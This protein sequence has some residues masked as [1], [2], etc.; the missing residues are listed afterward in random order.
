[1]IPKLNPSISLAD[2]TQIILPGKSLERFEEAFAQAAGSKYAISFPYGR[3]AMICLFE[4]LGLSDAEIIC[5]SYTCVVVPHAIRYSGNKPVFVDCEQGSYLMDLDL[6]AEAVTS[7]TRAIIVTSFFGEPVSAAAVARFRQRHPEV[8]VLQDCAH[9]F[10]CGGDHVPIHQN[11]KASIFGLNI[12]K[13][14]TSVFGGMVTTDDGDLNALIRAKRSARLHKAGLFKSIS[15]RIY[16]A[17]SA[18]ALSTAGFWATHRLIDWGLLARFVKYYDE[19]VI[20]MPKDYLSDMTS[21]EAAIGLHQ[22]RRFAKISDHRTQL[23]RKYL[24]R[25]SGIPNLTLPRDCDGRTWSHFTIK[26]SSEKLAGEIVASALR[27]GIELG[28]MLEYFIPD[29]PIYRSEVHLDRGVARG[30]VGKTFNLPLHC[31]VNPDVVDR[32]SNIIAAESAEE[33][34][35]IL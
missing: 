30:H 13:L 6:A 11:G 16:L 9:S 27:Q 8:I 19:T 25:L 17:T 18:C 29:M 23:A 33:P 1:M 20:D 34:L 21:F 31:N 5:P 28:R 4:A 14:I 15:R 35:Q 32:I 26:A 10:F 24:E 7:R 2:V 22:L 12:S 3:T